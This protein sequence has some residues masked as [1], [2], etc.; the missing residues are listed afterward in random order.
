[1]K[2]Y[3]LCSQAV[4]DHFPTIEKSKPFKSGYDW[5][6]EQCYIILASTSEFEKIERFYEDIYEQ[7]DQESKNLFPFWLRECCDSQL[8]DLRRGCLTSCRSFGVFTTIENIWGLTNE[9]NRAYAIYKMARWYGLN[10][11]EFINR[12]EN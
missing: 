11:I 1:M 3:Y 6:E 8:S 7:F 2:S 9:S 12:I 10:P 5:D 4:V